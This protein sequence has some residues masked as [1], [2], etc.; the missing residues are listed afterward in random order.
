MLVPT[1]TGTVLKKQTIINKQEK[2]YI[3]EVEY[4]I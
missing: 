1:L 3:N 4:F 2:I